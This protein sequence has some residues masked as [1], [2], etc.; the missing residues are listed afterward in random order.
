MLSRNGGIELVWV[1]GPAERTA[2]PFNP[3]IDNLRPDEHA[4]Y[5]GAAP[6]KMRARI[7]KKTVQGGARG[8]GLHMTGLAPSEASVD[9]QP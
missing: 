2:R 6:E 8:P 4:R 7:R 9:V 5:V 1:K 3:K